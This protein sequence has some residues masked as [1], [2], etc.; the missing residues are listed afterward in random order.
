MCANGRR[1]QALPATT[2]AAATTVLLL[3]LL[4]AAVPTAQAAGLNGRVVTAAWHAQSTPYKNYFDPHLKMASFYDPAWTSTSKDTAT[5]IFVGPGVEFGWGK[6][7]GHSVTLDMHDD[8]RLVL[9]LHCAGSHDECNFEDAHAT[10]TS[11]A[12]TGAS[13]SLTS[14]TLS[15]R[16]SMASL[17]AQDGILEIKL[18]DLKITTNGQSQTQTCE[19]VIVQVSSTLCGCVWRRLLG[20][21]S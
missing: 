14:S 19:F 1:C 5:N 21:H 7:A 8:G 11:T 10:V 12:F 2:T 20:A 4:P 18:H 13:L 9:A 16:I 15:G 6:D 17:H 3:T